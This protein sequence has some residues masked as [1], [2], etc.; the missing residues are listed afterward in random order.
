[1]GN[2]VIFTCTRNIL[3]WKLCIVHGSVKHVAEHS[4][5]HKR[6]A[7]QWGGNPSKLPLTMGGSGHPSN[8]WLLGSTAP[9]MPNAISTE[10]AVYSGLTLY[11]SYTLL[12]DS[13]F[14]WGDLDSHLIHGDCRPLHPTCQT[15]T[16]SVQPFLQDTCPLH[17][18][19]AYRLTNRQTTPHVS[20]N[21]LHLCYAYDAA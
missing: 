20:G 17:D 6:Y 14:P 5:T 11:Y 4:G 7:F 19:Q 16:R 9:H 13:P 12:W 1:M 21:R 18:R 15:A 8:T 2:N 10:P 3:A